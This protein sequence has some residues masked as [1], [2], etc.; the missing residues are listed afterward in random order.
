MP[1]KASPGHKSDDSG[2]C[3]VAGAI[4]RGIGEVL[5]AA[6][7]L[8]ASVWW[9]GR[10]ARVSRSRRARVAFKPSDAVGGPSEGDGRVLTSLADDLVGGL[11][12]AMFAAAVFAAVIRPDR[13]GAVL[14]RRFVVIATFGPIR[15]THSRVMA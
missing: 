9:R 6:T 3:N 12:C 14:K 11:R 15:C 2:Q 5:L 13:P 1:A 7:G 4:P 10:A 8:R